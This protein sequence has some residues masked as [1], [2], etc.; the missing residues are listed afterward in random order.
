MKGSSVSLV[1]ISIS[2]PSVAH[3]MN[4]TEL[5]GVFEEL[6][7]YPYLTVVKGS[8]PIGLVFRDQVFKVSN[9]SLTAGDITHHCCRVKNT[10]VTQE[11]IAGIL[12]LLPLEKEP[13][14]VVDKKGA[15][16][17]VITYDTV[18]LYITQ[19]KEF[20]LPVVQK[21]HSSL[22]KEEYLCVFG[23]KNMEDFKNLFGSGKAESVYK[24]LYED[25]KDFFEGEVSGVPEK[26]EIWIIS[27]KQPKKELIKDLFK[28]F[29][30]EYALLF[31]EF[32][33]VYVYGFCIDMSKIDSQEKLYSLKEE[34]RNR[35]RKIES[36]VFVVH[37][38][39][40]LLVLYDPSKQKIISNI[41]KKIMKDFKE[42]V[43]MVR[44]SPKDMWEH[45]LYDAF[46]QYPY[47]EL[48]Y[49]IGEKGLQ[50][51]N[52]IINPKADYFIA[53]GKKGS[54]RSDKAYFIKAIE[55]GSYISDIYLSKATDDF[56][57][58]VSERFVYEGKTY[59]LAGDINFRQIHKLVRSLREEAHLGS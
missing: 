28:E 5:K 44:S 55:E 9:E 25:I 53:Q 23:L 18:L 24:I 42:I 29:H 3:D 19:H 17:G 58:T 57:I 33:Q 2:V 10:Q 31:G 6:H 12:D 36:S 48:F 8:Y 50:I 30:R 7:I 52:N 43:E 51:T 59:V 49:I 26:G 16:L 13:A 47:F 46:D 39:Q 20:V 41:K 37:G 35:V 54:D 32:Q 1:D 40:P 27:S 11:S 22:G 38:L 4:I 56:C 15:Y 21:L 45:V 34:L 14:I